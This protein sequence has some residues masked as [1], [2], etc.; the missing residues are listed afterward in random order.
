MI[1]FTLCISVD[2][3]MHQLV[4]VNSIFKNSLFCMFLIEVVTKE[5]FVGDL[6]DGSEAA[7]IL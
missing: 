3:V 2:I 5:I 4:R 6:E 1:I 7:T